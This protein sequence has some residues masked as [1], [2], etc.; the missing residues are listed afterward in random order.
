MLSKHGN[1]VSEQVT[2]ISIG[3]NNDLES[4]MIRKKGT[5]KL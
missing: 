5:I 2:E 3:G 1:G 4:G